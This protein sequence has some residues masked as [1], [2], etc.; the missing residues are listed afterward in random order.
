MIQWPQEFEVLSSN[1]TCFSVSDGKFHLFHFN[2]I[3][4]GFYHHSMQKNFLT[5]EYT[6][7]LQKIVWYPSLYS[8]Q[9][10][11]QLFSLLPFSL[12][13]RLLVP[14]PLRGWGPGD[15][16]SYPCAG[17]QLVSWNIW[18]FLNMVSLCWNSFS[19]AC[20]WHL[21][22]HHILKIYCLHTTA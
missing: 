4:I 6:G 3:L 7:H 1:P 22:A 16:A 21:F 13:S 8:C 18:G 11:A 9:I 10:L 2:L 15:E 5:L 14:R 19:T 12:I 17:K 20:I